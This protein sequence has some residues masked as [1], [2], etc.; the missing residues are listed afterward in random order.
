MGRAL[1]REL[2]LESIFRTNSLFLSYT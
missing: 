2:L 1:P